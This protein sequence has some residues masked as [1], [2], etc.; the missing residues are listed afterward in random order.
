[1]WVTARSVTVALPYG[2]GDTNHP[3]REKHVIYDARRQGTKK[4]KLELIYSKKDTYGDS[5][6]EKEKPYRIEEIV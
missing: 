2:H 1:M 4:R 6:R 5:N 3:G